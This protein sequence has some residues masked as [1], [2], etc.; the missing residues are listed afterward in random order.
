MIIYL[1]ILKQVKIL[2]GHQI[3]FHAR[4][5]LFLDPSHLFKKMGR[6][7]EN[8]PVLDYLIFN[9]QNACETA[10]PLQSWHSANGKKL[11]SKALEHSIV[12]LDWTQALQTWR[13][14]SPTLIPQKLKG[15]TFNR[16]LGHE[17]KTVARGLLIL[18]PRFMDWKTPYSL[19]PPL[20][21][22]WREEKKKKKQRTAVLKYLY[23]SHEEHCMNS[24]RK[25]QKC[26]WQ[27]V[28]T[29]R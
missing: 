11:T 15:G 14:S 20:I 19:P 6:A 3:K 25:G 27:T 4:I 23:D 9:S 28:H 22:S 21:K 2:G 24:W 5:E 29:A 26:L 18:T 7:K 1:F 10:L 8:K 12:C 13:H 17:A 16:L